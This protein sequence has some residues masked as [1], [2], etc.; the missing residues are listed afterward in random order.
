M[1]DYPAEQ[2]TTPLR[3]PPPVAQAKFVKSATN[4]NEPVRCIFSKLEKY[5]AFA[6]FTKIV[7]ARAF[8]FYISSPPVFFFSFE[9]IFNCNRGD[10]MLCAL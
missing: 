7:R 9:D 1:H 8:P 3:F 4:F 10:R 5:F 2:A 6:A